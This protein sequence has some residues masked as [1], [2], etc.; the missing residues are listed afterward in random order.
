MT[1]GLKQAKIAPWTL[2]THFY[3][4]IQPKLLHKDW[5]QRHLNQYYCFLLRVLCVKMARLVPQF[6]GLPCLV[7]VE[8][9]QQVAIRDNYAFEACIWK[10]YVK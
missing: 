7:F 2:T 6:L 9:V 3:L 5:I 10:T 1:Q 4:I 8:H